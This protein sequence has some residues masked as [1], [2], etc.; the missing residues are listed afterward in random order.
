MLIG[1]VNN[2][3]VY[4][5]E[6]ND[7]YPNAKEKYMKNEKC[8]ISIIVGSTRVKC[9]KLVYNYLSDKG[10]VIFDDSQRKYYDE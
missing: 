6:L 3:T 2:G 5:E 10:V 1:V 9:A 7:F 8:D 4:Y